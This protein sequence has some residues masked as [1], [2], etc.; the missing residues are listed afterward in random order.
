MRIEIRERAF[1]LAS[2]IEAKWKQR[3]TCNWLANGDRNSR[4][5]HALASSR[6]RRNLVLQIQKGERIIR[7]PKGIRDSF[8]E[9]MTDILGTSSQVLPFDATALYGSNPTL[10]HLGIQF[11]LEEIELAVK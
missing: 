6:L 8:T 2:N 7:E 3:S 4:F 5:F 10:D 11:N 9:A 1:E